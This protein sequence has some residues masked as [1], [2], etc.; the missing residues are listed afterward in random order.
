MLAFKAENLGKM[1]ALARLKNKGKV[2]G[3]GKSF[4][5]RSLAVKERI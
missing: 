3:I 2:W 4:F 1:T 5:S